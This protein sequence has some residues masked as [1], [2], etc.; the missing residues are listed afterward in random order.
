MERAAAKSA[1]ALDN[2]RVAICDPHAIDEISF[3]ELNDDTVAGGNVEF[4]R[5]AL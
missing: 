2:I 3:D 1:L 5:V 4:V